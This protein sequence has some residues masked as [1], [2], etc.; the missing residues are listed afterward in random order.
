MKLGPPHPGRILAGRTTRATAAAGAALLASLSVVA[1]TTGQASA[2]S[3]CS[4]NYT[5]SSQWN[6]G[7]S[8]N[9]TITN[10]GSAL[11][12]WSLKWSFGGNQQ[13]TQLWNG[14]YTQSGAAVTVNNLSYNGAIATNGTASLG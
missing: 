7:F 13:I 10:L 4:V 14:S 8:T 5:I 3:G 12:S 2:A 9:I 1:L 6:V 11:T